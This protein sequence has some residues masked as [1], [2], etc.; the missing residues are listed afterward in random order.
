MTCYSLSQYLSAAN[1]LA[2]TLISAHRIGVN[3]EQQSWG[4]PT[5]YI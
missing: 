3:V 1:N 5:I 2:M 4:K